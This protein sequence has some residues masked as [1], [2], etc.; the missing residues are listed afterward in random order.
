MS[1]LNVLHQPEVLQALG[2]QAP[3]V[4]VVFT[5]WFRHQTQGLDL[6]LLFSPPHENTGEGVP[7]WIY[8]DFSSLQS[9]PPC[10]WSELPLSV[11]L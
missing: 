3:V 7:H 2:R 11:G 9:W 1:C 8:F 10:G 4:A 5:L 6:P